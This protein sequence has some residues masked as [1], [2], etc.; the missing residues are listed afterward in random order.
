MKN[1]KQ[2]NKL[3]K[4]NSKF[5]LQYIL[6]AEFMVV[7]V[8]LILKGKE[9]LNWGGEERRRKRDGN[10]SARKILKQFS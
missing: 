9:G 2:A 5:I 1:N 6:S 8:H 10:R 4:K 3:R 7:D